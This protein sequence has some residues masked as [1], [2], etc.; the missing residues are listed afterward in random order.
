M[1]A[2]LSGIITLRY[3]GPEGK[4][5][6]TFVILIPSMIA[7]FGNFGVAQSATYF[8]DQNKY[9][10][11]EVYNNLLNWLLISGTCLVI[12][13]ISIMYLIPEFTYRA[14]LLLLIPT[15][16]FQVGSR[17]ISGFLLGLQELKSYNQ[18]RLLKSGSLIIGYI[19]FLIIMKWHLI[20]AF[21]AWLI[22]NRLEFG[23]VF[24]KTYSKKYQIK[25]RIDKSWL[26]RSLQYGK[27]S[28]CQ[29]P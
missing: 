3:L 28:I 19:C 21:I 15:I 10:K 5:I 13:C 1:I 25:F 7:M 6:F 24:L 20:G 2:L 11:E 27:K 8:I 12:L 18:A 26:I 4:G 22:S 23:F 14:Y 29:I 17:F 16:Y 9:K